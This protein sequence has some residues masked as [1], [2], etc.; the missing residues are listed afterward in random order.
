METPVINN[1]NIKKK[2]TKFHFLKIVGKILLVLFIVIV[3]LILFVRSHF[4]Q[5]IIVSKLTSFVSNKTNTKVEIEKLFITFDG[6]IQLDGLYLEDKIGDTLIYSKSLEANVPLWS[7]ISGKG[8]GVDALDWNGL[9]AN[10]I[11]KDSINGFNFQFLVDAFATE[12]TTTADTT[13][14][15]SPSIVLGKLNL[16]N[17]NVVYNDGVSGIDSRFNI[18]ALNIEMEQVNLEAMDFKAS[19][20]KL[21]DTKIKFFQ[22][23]VPIDPNSEATPLP[24]LSAEKLSLRNV[25]ADYK[26]QADRLAA[27]INIGELYTEIPTANLADN[28]IEINT[29]N[30]KQSDIS[31]Y[32]ETE[33]DNII[34]KVREGSGD[35]NRGIKNFEWPDLRIT[36]NNINFKNNN[37]G[38]FVGNAK[39]NKNNFNPN[40]LKFNNLNLKGNTIYLRDEKGRLN[41]ESLSFR[42]ASG[43]NLNH[44]ALN[45]SVTDKK[46][47]IDNLKFKLNNNDIVG[48][49]KLDYSSLTSL[50]NRPEN[51]RIALNLPNFQIDLNELFKLQPNL[52]SNNYLI[53][54]SKKPV[55]GTII[56]NGYLSNINLQNALINWG[57][58]T[59][60]S[61]KGNIR[62]PTSPDKLQL[63][64]PSFSV[65]T[66]KSDFTQFINESDLGITLPE[67]V[68]LIGSLKGGLDS[69]STTSKIKTSQGVA[70]VDGF[71]KNTHTIAFNANVTLDNYNLSQLLK[72][73][74]L[75]NLS[76][77]LNA[78]GSGKTINTLNADAEALI[79]NFSY[80]KYALKNLKINGN[81]KNGTGKIL[82]NYKDDNINIDLNALVTL[83]SIAPEAKFN[84]NLIGA[85]L[86]GLGLMNRDIRTGLELKG[87]F[88]GNAENYKFDAD[89]KDGIVVYDNK[90]YLLGAINATGFVRNDTTS[91]KFQNKLIN[92]NLQSNTDPQRFSAAVKNHLYSYFYRDVDRVETDTLVKPIDV[93]LKG[94]IVQSPL[95]KDVLLVNVKDLDTISIAVDFKQAERKLMADITAPHINYSGIELDSLAFKMNTN[96]TDLNFDFGFKAL[97]VGKIDI[98]RTQIS[99]DQKD[100]EMLL[101]FTAYNDNDK[102]I[103]VR[104]Q[105]TGSREDLRL[106]ILQE[107]LIFNQEPWNIP[108]DNQ[109]IYTKESLKFNNFIISKGNQSVAITDRIQKVTRPHVALDFKNFSLG[110]F[111]SYFNTEKT[112]ASGIIDGDFILED[113]FKDTGILADIDIKNLE[114]LKSDLGKL[115]ITGRSL[116]GNNY[117]FNTT[118][119]GGAIDLDLV[120]DYE[121]NKNGANLDLRLDINTFKMMALEKFSLGFL[122]ETKGDFSG[123]FKLNGTIAEPKYEG[124]LKFNNAGFNVAM[125]NAAFSL[126]N[127]A[128]SINNKGL[129]L[130]NFTVKDKDNNRLVISGNIGTEQFINPTFNLDIKAN[131]FQFLNATKEDNDFF[132]GT[133]R[134]NADGK[135]TGN[136]QIPKLNANA[137]IGSNTDVTYVMPSASVNVEKRDGIVVFVNR[138]NPNAILTETVEQSATIKGFDVKT[139]LKVEDQATVTIIIDKDTGDYFKVSGKGDF[140]FTMKPNGRMN[141]VGTY[142]VDSGLYEMNLYNLVNRTFELA[143]GSKVSWSGDPFDAQLDIRAIYNLKASASP[144]MLPQLSGADPSVRSKYRQVLPFYVYLNID[145]ELLA[146]KISFKLD[147]PEND[148][149]AIGGQVYGRVQQVN[150]QEDELNRQVFSL[151][152]LNRFYPEP[153]SDGSTGGFATI[154][155]DNL[156]DAVSDQLNSFSNKLLGDSSF[157]LDF[158]LDSYTDYQGNT[159]QD[160]TQLN[161]A[162]QKRLFDD[163]LIVRVGSEVDLQGS[164]STGEATPLVG[165]VSLEYLLTKNGRYKLKGFRRNEFENVIDGQTIVSGIGLIFTQEFNKFSELWEAILFNETKAEKQDRVRLKKEQE[166][167]TKEH[168]N[169]EKEKTNEK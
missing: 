99:G 43:L 16:K 123:N 21:S 61:A 138:K 115:A 70:T 135:L 108:L 18:G 97:K 144:L 134:F 41:L 71:F 8:I 145:G 161:V 22:N 152:V 93:L 33:E 59:H 168:N 77:T 55:Q 25:Y 150:Q 131:D 127:E 158:G 109:M 40:A 10:I 118:L 6:D 24:K 136:L 3:L 112:L 39:V 88:K 116:G 111:L 103:N 20:I 79:S 125:F 100:N 117:A 60:I 19:N 146:P 26:S 151:L 12:S 87:N 162:A 74:T 92:V 94:H 81:I 129:N 67:D 72:N 17:I 37:I 166:L 9:R 2:K 137:T 80:N 122:K 54:L 164:S 85:N 15:K 130:T 141:L 35:L 148:Q 121:A 143:P 147:M 159:P 29:L 31:I 52:K 23:A 7:I 102:L 163:R 155:R 62:N 140:D 113:P 119:K 75:G 124:Q 91:V 44:L 58:T 110:D 66:I 42:E 76:L 69:M 154:A 120:G 56:A 104:S 84:L 96:K 63:N 36:I 32:T 30:L 11:R 89:I 28:T 160:R 142:N 114:I 14:A 53:A 165:N 82:S 65:T 156:N 169:T 78:T 27:N 64:I 98:D 13:T 45:F 4:G 167:K 38:F 83:D 5:D 107:E 46:L 101:A 157:E 48:D 132:Y 128:L 73:E 34:E 1:E 126:E 47:V 51:S 139:F 153:G 57:N 68:A 50:V 149:G 133:A 49:V 106:K 105:I 90:T 95:L 86:Q